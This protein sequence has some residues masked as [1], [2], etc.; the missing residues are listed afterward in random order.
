[1]LLCNVGWPLSCWRRAS[2]AALLII[3]FGWYCDGLFDETFDEFDLYDACWLSGDGSMGTGA[4]GGVIITGGGT[5]GGGGPFFDG[6][7]HV[8]MSML[9]LP[10]TIGGGGIPGPF[11]FKIDELEFAYETKN[12]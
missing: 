8:P 2:L 11:F 10:G 4:G 12:L 6:V 9:C 5:N 1:M 7:S 3:T